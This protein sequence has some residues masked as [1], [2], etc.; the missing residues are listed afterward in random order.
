MYFFFFYFNYV[1]FSETDRILYPLLFIKFLL[2]HIKFLNKIGKYC[3]RN[4]F[5]SHI[6]ICFSVGADLNKYFFFKTNE[7]YII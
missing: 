2:Y 6:N 3:L 4:K 1:F 7:N 5:F